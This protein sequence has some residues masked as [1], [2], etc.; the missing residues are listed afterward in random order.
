MWEGGGEGLEDRLV[1]RSVVSRS[2]EKE[3]LGMGII[4]KSDLALLGNGCGN[5][6]YKRNSL[7][8][9]VI[10]INSFYGLHLNGLCSIMVS[11]GSFRSQWNFIS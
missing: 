11:R 6:L 1:S 9:K 2:K 7:L 4:V 8:C 3:C 10:M 5:Y